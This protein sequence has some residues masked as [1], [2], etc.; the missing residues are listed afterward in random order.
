MNTRIRSAIN[1]RAH[2]LGRAYG[3]AARHKLQTEVDTA[4]E[5]GADHDALLAI[6]ARVAT[7]LEVPRAAG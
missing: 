5:A 4:I 1:I 6:I 7:E 3:D 2:E